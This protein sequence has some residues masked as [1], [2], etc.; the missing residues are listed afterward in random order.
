MPFVKV[1]IFSGKSKEYKKKLLDSIHD[2]LVEAFKIPEDDRMQRLYELEPENFE[3][4][5]GKTENFTMIELTVFPGRSLEAKRKLYSTIV[6]NLGESLSI[7]PSDVFIVIN[8]PPLENWGIR[9]G[10]AAI[11]IDLGFKIDV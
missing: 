7:A 5:P 1:E 9:G 3:T 2:A 4:V 10:K 8:E 6:K 11:D